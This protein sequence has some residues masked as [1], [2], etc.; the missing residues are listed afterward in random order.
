MENSVDNLIRQDV[1][2]LGAGP[3]GLA[4]AWHLKKGGVS[5][6]LIEQEQTVGASWRQMPEHLHL[7][8]LWKSNYLVEEDKTA[9][10]PYHKL[11]AKEFADYLQQFQHRHQFPV[12]YNCKVEQI[13]QDPEGLMVMTSS[14]N[15]RARLIVD[16]RGYFSHPFIPAMQH[17][18]ELPR[19]LHFKDY[20][21]RLQLKDYKNILIVGKKL[22]AGQLLE[23]LAAS[24]DHQLFLSIRSPLRYGPPPFFLRLYLRHLDVFESFKHIFPVT[25]KKSIDVPMDFSAKK[26]IEG[27]VRLV[28]DITRIEEKNVYFT[29]GEIHHIDAIIFATGFQ[30]PGIN[31]RDDFESA[32]IKNVFYLGRNC[33]RTFASRFIRGIREDAKIL[34][35]RIC[36]TLASSK[37]SQ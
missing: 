5:F 18:G 15:Y 19:I 35:K 21:N 32:E 22:S 16:C 28:P 4:L 34:G 36:G 9:F 23:E 37:S 1:L 3:A 26:I 30:P 12:Q 20:K 24:G 2:I 14:G 7:I 33:Q 25:R 17:N 27:Q 13:K 6:L 8:T 11:S 10:N 29:N 31:L